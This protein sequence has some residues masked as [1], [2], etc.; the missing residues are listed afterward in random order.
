[1]Y[2]TRKKTINPLALESDQAIAQ[3]ARDLSVNQNTLVEHCEEKLELGWWNFS[4]LIKFM[5]TGEL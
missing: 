5:E 3:A 4:S 2:K 1:M